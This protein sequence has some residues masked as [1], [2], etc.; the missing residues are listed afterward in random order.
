M[1]VKDLIRIIGNYDLESNVLL[2]ISGDG[3]YKLCICE[4]EEIPIEDLIFCI[5]ND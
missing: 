3:M 5:D 4:D 2:E 1:K